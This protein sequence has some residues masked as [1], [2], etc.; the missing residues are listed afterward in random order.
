MSAILSGEPVPV[1]R[2]RLEREL[3]AEGRTIA[4]VMVNPSTADAVED[5]HTIRKVAGFAQRFAGR[6]II[7]GNKFAYRATD[8]RAL[9]DAADPVGPEN[10][11]HIEQILRDADLHIV[12]WGP[13]A[14]LPKPLRERWRAVAAIAD[15]VGCR[16]HCLGTAADGHPRHPLMLAYASLLTPWRGPSLETA[17]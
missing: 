6:R 12:A 11:R 2:Y 13:M 7:V 5:D 9:R 1:Y 3:Q 8:V 10:D 4:V 17:R 16:L 15:R 14:K